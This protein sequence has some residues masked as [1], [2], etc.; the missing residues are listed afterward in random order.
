ME[1]EKNNKDLQEHK[2]ALNKLYS[3]YDF[4]TNP[5]GYGLSYI[6]FTRSAVC[7]PIVR[8]LTDGNVLDA[9]SGYG[10]FRRYTKGRMHIGI[11][12]SQEI[13]RH[14]AGRTKVQSAV[15]YL[16]FADRSI[17]NVV[18]IGVLRHCFD[19]ALFVAEAKRVLKPGGRLLVSTPSSDWPEN[20]MKT[21]WK[22]LVLLSNV[23]RFIKSIHKRVLTMFSPQCVSQVPLEEGGVVYDRRYT[24]E[25]LRDL[26]EKHFD[27]IEQGRSG[28]DFPSSLHPPKW[29]IKSHYDEAKLGRFLFISCSKK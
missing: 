7:A 11:D 16:P 3:D 23:E 21:P 17:D 14:D 19:P 1:L 13:M 25:Q 8:S 12:L 24:A 4:S 10:F 5:W 15:E 26:V 22:Y 20:L 6:E 28:V 27:V 29:L 2:S 9:G 18:C